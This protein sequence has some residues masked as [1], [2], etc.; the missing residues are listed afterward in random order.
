M[1]KTLV[2]YDSIY[3]NT[4]R[5]AQTIAEATGGLVRRAVDVQPGDWAGLDLLIVGSPTHGGWYTEAIRDL[6]KATPALAGVKVACFDTRTRSKIGAFLFGFA[7]PRIA[8]SLQASG[9]RLVAPP[10]GFIVSGT[11]GPLLAGELERAAGWARRLVE[12]A[13]L[14]HS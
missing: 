14:A 2:I 8:R 11:Q 1:A 3:G 12:D 7:A 6:L 9:G 5:I 4:E 10:E 13:V